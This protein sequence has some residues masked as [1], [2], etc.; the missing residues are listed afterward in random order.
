MRPTAAS[1]ACLGALDELES[2]VFLLGAN[3]DKNGQRQIAEK[4]KLSAILDARIDRSEIIVE[5]DEMPDP[6]PGT[7][8]STVTILTSGTTGTPKAS[9]HTWQSLFRP[10]RVGVFGETPRW[11]LTYQPHL[12]AGLQVM[13]QCFADYG[14]LVV[15]DWRANTDEIVKRISKH[16]VQFASGTPS[17][18]RRFLLFADPALI[19]EVRLQHIAL[20]GEVVD[21]NVLDLIKDRFPSARVTH[22][23]ATTELGRCFSVTDGLAGFPRRFLE[24]ESA[25]GIMLRIEDGQL[26]VK[27]ANAMMSYDPL[28]EQQVVPSEWFATGDMVDVTADRV[29]FLGRHADVINVGGNKVH[30]LEVESEIRSV[31]GVMDARVYPKTSSIAGQLVACQIVVDPNF[32]A[33]QVRTIVLQQCGKKLLAFQRPR[34]VE[35][36]PELSLSFAGKAIRREPMGTN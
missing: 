23:Y 22:I 4:F 5:T 34:F 15:S 3:L 27:S 6:M 14:T 33:N 16:D 2:D 21:Q 30:P 13:C 12:Y 25:D 36:V 7:G 17:F 35:V 31:Q 18:W 1:V 10:V 24:E 9:R 32:D 29:Y 19:R 20:G 26:F 8:S 28:S 11:M